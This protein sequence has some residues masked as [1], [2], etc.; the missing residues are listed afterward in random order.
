MTVCRVQRRRALAA[1]SV[2]GALV[3]TSLASADVAGL[4]I[5]DTPSMPRGLWRVVATDSAPLRDGAVVTICPPD[6]PP[7]RVGAGRG[8]LPPGSCPGGYEPLVKPI[9]ATA[10]DCVTVSAAGE[11]PRA[12]CWQAVIAKN[13]NNVMRFMSARSPSG[14]G[15]GY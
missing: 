3:M 5:N 2:A 6:T 15:D 13:A 7:I 11:S 9:A 14:I 10:G 4:R 1:S 12:T 8:Y